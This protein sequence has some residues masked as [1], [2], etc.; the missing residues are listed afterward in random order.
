VKRR[1][2]PNIHAIWTRTTPEELGGGG[3]VSATGG[4]S[5]RRRTDIVALVRVLPCS[6]VCRDGRSVASEG[7]G[8]RV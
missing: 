5:E 8:F 3:G 6:E 4:G 1:A 2:A 7:S